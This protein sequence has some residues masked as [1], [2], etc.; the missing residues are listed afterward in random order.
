MSSG[1]AMQVRDEVSADARRGR[2]ATAPTRHLRALPPP[3]A[4]AEVV[5]P[6]IDAGVRG[7][8]PARARSSATGRPQVESLPP[9]RLT[10][11]GRR[12]VAV[13]ALL[14]GLGVVALGGALLGEA[15]G[16]LELMGTTKVVVEP[17]DTLWSI[18]GTVSGGR[19]VRDVVVDIRRLNELGSAAITPGQVLELP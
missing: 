5:A 14:L 18:A 17:G 6:R 15:G 3:R 19:D 11:R 1:A 16:G 2:S 7:E 10:A 9:L 4:Y 12:V 8:G 13:A